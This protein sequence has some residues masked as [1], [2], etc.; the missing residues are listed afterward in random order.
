MTI[1]YKRIANDIVPC[2][3]EDGEK[4]P[5]RAKDWERLK[6]G[7]WAEIEPSRAVYS[8]ID[9]WEP[10][11]DKPYESDPGAFGCEIDYTIYD[12][13]ECECDKHSYDTYQ[14]RKDA[15]V[16]LTPLRWHPIA[17]VETTL[18]EEV[19]FLEDA[20]AWIELVDFV[21]GQVTSRFGCREDTL[22]ALARRFQITM[23]F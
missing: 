23:R 9:V 16:R 21:E 15:M 17:N 8:A 19:M 14:G 5:F 3:Y 7:V 11:L 6:H 22:R 20:E 18:E 1:I 13:K 12:I 4:I 2:L 10:E